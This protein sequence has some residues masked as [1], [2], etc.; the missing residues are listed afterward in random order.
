MKL[1]LSNEH[2]SNVP[3]IK[4]KITND[5]LKYDVMLT[6]HNAAQVI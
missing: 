5:E 6:I 3:L 4:K 1:F 2:N